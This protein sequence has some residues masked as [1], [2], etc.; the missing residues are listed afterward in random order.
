[1]TAASKWQKD[2]LVTKLFRG[3]GP[4]HQF[5]VSDCPTD[6]EPQL[7]SVDDAR[8]RLSRI[9]PIVGEGQKVIVT[10]H[11]HSA[12]LR[13]AGQQFLI[14][15]VRATVFQCGQDIDSKASRTA[16]DGRRN[17]LVEIERDHGCA[18]RNFACNAGLSLR[19]RIDSTVESRCS[20]SRFS[21]SS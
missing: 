17:V 16:R 15:G 14:A 9:E 2:D 18:A 6:R 1:M 11:D 13:G 10:S 21:S 12:E 3:R 19:W 5:Q 4:G 8:K 20:M 7:V